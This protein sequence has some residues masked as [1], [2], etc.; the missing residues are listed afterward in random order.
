MIVIDRGDRGI[1]KMPLSVK[2]PILCLN[3]TTDRGTEVTEAFSQ[4]FSVKINLL[5]R[6]IK[7][8]SVILCH[9]PIL[10]FVPKFDLFLTEGQN[11]VLCHASVKL[12][13]L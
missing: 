12:E 4:I 13:M 9:L 1:E 10:V 3:S 6:N 2:T 5:R 11:K 8:S 7:K